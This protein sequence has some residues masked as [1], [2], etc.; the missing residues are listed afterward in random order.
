MGTCRAKEEGSRR[1]SR[2]VS[3]PFVLIVD[4]QQYISYSTFHH[5]ARKL[6]GDGARFTEVL[7]EVSAGS[8]A[9]TFAWIRVFFKSLSARISISAVVFQLRY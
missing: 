6:R 9:S 1:P 2:M 3:H 7:F 5:S 4:T 8:F